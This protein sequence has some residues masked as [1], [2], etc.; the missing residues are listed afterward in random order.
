MTGFRLP[1]HNLLRRQRG[2]GSDTRQL[3]QQSARRLAVGFEKGFDRGLSR[4]ERIFLYMPFQHSEDRADQAYSV[5]LFDALSV[6]MA[7]RSAKKHFEIV[8]RF[9]RFPHR[10]AS[11]GRASTP[12]EK[13][14][15]KTATTWGQGGAA[16]PG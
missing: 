14:Y 9:G 8:A 4:V 1:G 5:A 12:E 15:L 7:A 3:G 6:E 16:T 2:S 10:N 13:A 11:L